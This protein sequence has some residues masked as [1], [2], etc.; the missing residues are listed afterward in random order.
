MLAAQNGK[1]L[2]EV[3][4]SGFLEKESPGFRQESESHV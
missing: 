4:V 3:P 1:Q 2:K